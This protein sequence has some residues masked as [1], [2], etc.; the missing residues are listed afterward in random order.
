MDFFHICL[1]YAKFYRLFF[2][3][4][5]PTTLHLLLHIMFGKQRLSSGIAFR[6]HEFSLWIKQ[7]AKT[8]CGI[9][10][11]ER[12]F[13]MPFQFINLT[14]TKIFFSHF[15]RSLRLYGP[16]VFVLGIVWNLW[17][18]SWICE[19][20]KEVGILLDLSCPGLEY[21]FGVVLK[22]YFPSLWTAL[23]MWWM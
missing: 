17:P 22:D 18:F 20:N 4:A 2:Q 19:E 7:K 3:W 23:L 1:I 8:G 11:C 15:W 13:V 9:Y 10:W 12:N 5:F 16:H 6:Q 21:V 14:G